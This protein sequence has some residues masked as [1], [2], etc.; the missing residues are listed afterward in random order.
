MTISKAVVYRPVRGKLGT[1][2]PYQAGNRAWI[3][4]TLGSRIP[5]ARVQGGYGCECTRAP[6]EMG[7]WE[8]ARHHLW[9]LAE[10][11]VDRYGE[12]HVFMDFSRRERCDVR[13]V[14]AA[15]DE[16]VCACGG[17]NHRGLATRMDGWIE[18]GETTLVSSGKSLR[19][20]MKWA[21]GA[22]DPVVVGERQ[23]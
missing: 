22:L 13:C 16:C 18:V 14:E 12:V 19:R 1:V 20:H 9:G 23:I 15:G 7:H 10:A 6:G 11:L 4:E 3:K 17:A 21:K 8:V 2:F 5:V